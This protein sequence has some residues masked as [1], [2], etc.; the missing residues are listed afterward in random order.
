MSP[1][2]RQSASNVRASALRRCAL[3]L[4][5]LNRVHLRTIGR[6]EQELGTLLFQTLGGLRA[7]S[8]GTAKV[9]SPSMTPGLHIRRLAHMPFELPPALV[10]VAMKGQTPLWE[11][12]AVAP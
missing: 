9:R 7:L 5:L 8:R 2:A 11:E 1:S 12:E 6:Q 4:G 10:K 3:I